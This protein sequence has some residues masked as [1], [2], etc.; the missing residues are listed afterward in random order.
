M[1]RILTNVNQ[2][3]NQSIVALKLCIF[4]DYKDR[5]HDI[6]QATQRLRREIA[7]LE[8]NGDRLRD[9][10]EVLKEKLAEANQ[11]LIAASRLS[12]QLESSQQ[13]VIVL[14][15]E[16]KKVLEIMHPLSFAII[17]IICNHHS[18]GISFTT[19]T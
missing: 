13:A 1:V 15:E 19:N 16:G 14:R 9:E 5:Q 8:E 2:S 3:I 17:V 10:L 6:E 4:L 7:G 12:D 18:S 11:G